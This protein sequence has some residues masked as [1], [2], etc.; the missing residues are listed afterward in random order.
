MQTAFDATITVG[1]TGDELCLRLTIVPRVKVDMHETVIQRL[2]AGA[3]LL[4]FL[5]SACGDERESDYFDGIAL[6]AM[7]LLASGCT[8]ATNV[9]TVKVADGE[10]V[11]VTL[12]ASDSKVTVNGHV[13]NGTTDTGTSCEIAST[14]TINIGVDAPG[15]PYVKGRAVILDYITGLFMIGAA[16]LPGI[17]VDFTLAGDSGAR[18]WLKIRGSD[19]AD[20]FAVGAGT[21]AGAAAVYALNVN[22]KFGTAPTQPGGTGGATVTLDLGPDVT[23]KLAPNVMINGGGGDDRLDASGSSGQ[24]VRRRW[25]RHAARRQRCRHA[26]RG[27]RRRYAQRLSGCRCL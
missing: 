4:L 24:A 27:A 14:G 25:Q 6:S 20:M 11:L 10:S 5:V 22:T 19:G 8:I 3:S 18:N 7:P 2:I 16:A 21:G 1:Q 17:K 12:R 13:F 15:A 23:F 26:Q 9:M